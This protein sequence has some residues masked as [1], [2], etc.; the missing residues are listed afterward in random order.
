[1]SYK[2]CLN[3]I[4]LLEHEEMSCCDIFLNDMTYENSLS[5]NNSS[6]KLAYVLIEALD[7]VPSGESNILFGKIDSITHR[8]KSFGKELNRNELIWTSF[9][10]TG[11]KYEK[12]GITKQSITML[13][14][15]ETAYRQALE[16][17]NQDQELSFWFDTRYNL[18]IVLQ[19]LGSLTNSEKTL[20]EAETAY[21]IALR[22]CDQNETPDDWTKTQLN[23]GMVLHTLG[24]L[25]GSEVILC[26]SEIIYRRALEY[27]SQNKKRDDEAKA[28]NNFGSLLQS[29]G[30]LTE[31]EEILRNAETAYQRALEIEWDG[32]TPSVRAM[33][34]SNLCLVL[35]NLGD[36][37]NS[38]VTLLEAEAVCIKALKYY[39]Q[40]ETA[41]DWA[42][43]QSNLCMILQCLGELIGSEEALSRAV[44]ASEKALEVFSDLEKTSASWIGTQINY[45]TALQRLGD[46][47][48]SEEILSRAEAV[49]RRILE[50]LNPGKTLATWAKVQL[51]LGSILTTL[52]DLTD[53][54]I[55]LRKGEAEYRKALEFYL[56]DKALNG[57]AKCQH[58]LAIV[59]RKWEDISP[60]DVDL[61]V[62]RQKRQVELKSLFFNDSA[63]KSFALR[64]RSI[65]FGFQEELTLQD[66]NIN[67]VDE[68][69]HMIN[70]AER[71]AIVSG[72]ARK[73][74]SNLQ[75]LGDELACAALIDEDVDSAFQYLNL[76]R[77][78]GL[79]QSLF[80][81][82]L[83]N[84]SFHKLRFQLQ[85]VEIQL[86]ASN[87]GQARPELLLQQRKLRKEISGY[88]DDA[89]KNGQFTF[90][91]TPS[92]EE[93]SRALSSASIDAF[94]MLASARE[95]TVLLIIKADN[96]KIEV[97]DLSMLNHE[98]IEN[99][100][101]DWM[102][103]YGRFVNSI[104]Q[105]AS[106]RI[107]NM[108][109]WNDQIVS[110]QT[111]LWELFLGPVDHAL[112]DI[113]LEHNSKIV[114]MLPGSLTHLPWNAAVS[115]DGTYFFERWV[116]S[117]VPSANALV[118]CVDRIDERI[119][120]GSNVLSITDPLGD[121][122]PKIKET[123]NPADI[124]FKDEQITSLLAEKAHHV[125]VKDDLAGKNII[126]F[127]CHGRWN[128]RFPDRSALELAPTDEKQTSAPFTVRDIRMS[129]LSH[130]RL[131]LLG[132][133]DSGL[134][135]MDVPDEMT[136]LP[137]AFI[138]A[139]APAAIGTIWPVIAKSTF[140]INVSILKHFK[141]TRHPALALQ[142][143][144]K[145]F[146]R[147]GQ[148]VDY[149]DVQSVQKFDPSAPNPRKE[150]SSTEENSL[151]PNAPVYW[152]PFM[153]VGW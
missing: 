110:T 27:F 43:T 67:S 66:M 108:I 16:F 90:I 9:T 134:P 47:I 19:N 45:G 117:Q 120:Q 53:S 149:S 79:N 96:P 152:A 77:V 91:F 97:V 62:A 60:T 68:I 100:R 13:R 51:N 26:E 12:Y 71:E 42:R 143:A 25:T 141:E 80:L 83:N 85:S 17:C 101:W 131:V 54:E 125:A 46:F 122:L 21:R 151:P 98:A 78:R 115:P 23:L 136:G 35:Y 144:V 76:I 137:T 18:G 63:N 121:I 59:L 58:N 57:W 36:L 123:K 127:Y 15:A 104:R 39:N 20:R 94:V 32:Q 61:L 14:E 11:K 44:T 2:D 7:V 106:A 140:D 29:L 118:H 31:S 4:N 113:G 130:S 102:R 6:I 75:G 132:A 49:F 22:Y 146:V 1:M 135:G 124:V 65:V 147:G 40:S 81:S 129:D 116:V 64:L 105:N 138:E 72:E 33:I 5:F 82:L 107:S 103:Q 95:K 74:I 109:A 99:I 148:A 48:D 150:D 142:T 133:C 84:E 112:Q 50:I 126:S 24:D 89:E 145:E 52:G 70:K 114:F 88:L 34:N 93:T 153:M 111:R 37:T 30:A 55:F 86:E 41:T 69:N 87:T 92:V 10:L 38:E 128:H 139:G 73:L 3:T 8:L 56:Q 119:R 28:L